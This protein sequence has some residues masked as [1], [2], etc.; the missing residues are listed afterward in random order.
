MKILICGDSWT[1]GYGV[2]NRQSWPNYIGHEFD[3]VARDGVSNPEILDQFLKNYNDTYNAAIIGWSGSTRNRKNYKLLEFSNADVDTANF[4]K[5]KSLDDILKSWENCIDSVL[6]TT[7]IPI[8]QFSVFGDMPLKKYENFLEKSFLEFLANQS[9]IYFKYKIP[10][11]EFDWLHQDN[12]H[13]TGQFAKKYFDKNWKKAC[14]EREDLRPGKYFL[15]CGHPNQH[16]HQLW[17][18]YIK[19]IL[20]DSII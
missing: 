12:Y 17:G 10:I 18:N 11:F 5:D 13:L 14:V 3:N 8:L 20:N 19:D 9:G 16:G 6:E 15:S 4:F 1:Q 2:F 7:K